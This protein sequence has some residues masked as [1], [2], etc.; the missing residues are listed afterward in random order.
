MTNDLVD[1][2][3]GPA[4]DRP[5]TYQRLNFPLPVNVGVGVSCVRIDASERH[6]SGK[7]V[8]YYLIPGNHLVALRG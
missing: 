3:L 8:T 2:A 6:H 4:A 1:L 7:H 5:A